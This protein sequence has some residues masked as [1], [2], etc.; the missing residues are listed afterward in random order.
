MKNIISEAA[1]ND[2][3]IRELLTGHQLMNQLEHYR[4]A[5]AAQIAQDYR[6]LGVKRGSKLRHVAEIPQRE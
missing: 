6:K 2:A 5:D 1:L 3:V 4:E